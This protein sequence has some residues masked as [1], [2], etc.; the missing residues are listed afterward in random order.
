[1]LAAAAGYADRGWPV[2]VLGRS[3]RPVANCDACRTAG[4]DH[5]PDA[6]RCL[7]CHS[8]YA[9]TCDRNRIVAM[10][11]AVPT[12]MLAIRTGTAS[13]LAIID[14][15][16]RNG[17]TLDRSLMT[18][19]AAVRTG[20][21]GWHLYYQHPGGS[22]PSRP[23][24]PGVDLKADGG[25]VVAPPSRNPTTGLTYQWT[26]TR[27]VVEMPPALVTA[28]RTP[29]EE[30]RPVAP[31]RTRRPAAGQ[32]GTAPGGGGIS[33]PAALLAAHLAA[34]DRAPEGRRRTTLYGAARGVARLVAAGHLDLTDAI[35]ALTDAGHH[36]DQTDRD[37][38]AAITGAFRDEGVPT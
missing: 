38:T 2:F 15:D 5:D 14:I 10:L 37:I 27:P 25:L 28:A 23:L 34:I 13:G 24:L 30:P 22:L 9:A 36:A 26:G 31:G 33:D 32:H 4:P 19:T 8:F 7:T 29:P 18:P 20:G 1:M 6:C 21:G 17:G 16:P 11:A 3:K 12:G 35:T